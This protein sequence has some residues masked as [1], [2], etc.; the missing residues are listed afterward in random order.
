MTRHPFGASQMTVESTPRAIRLEGRIY[1][2]HNARDFAPIRMIGSG[3]EKAHIGHGLLLVVWRKLGRTGR[4][5][6]D[7]GIGRH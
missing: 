6:C 7:L 4:Q 3:I 5:V 1:T 2:K